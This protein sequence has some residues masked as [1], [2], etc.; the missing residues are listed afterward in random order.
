[1]SI[2]LTILNVPHS[3]ENIDHSYCINEYDA[4][5]SEY[6]IDEKLSKSIYIIYYSLIGDI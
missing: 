4:T 6:I 2:K 1:M 3:L 5:V